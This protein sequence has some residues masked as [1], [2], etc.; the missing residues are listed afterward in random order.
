M[1][2]KQEAALR[3]A[4]EALK[5]SH[6]EAYRHTIT[7]IDEALADNALDKMADNARELGLDY[8]PAQQQEPVCDKC[9]GLGY[10]DEGHEC[11]DGSMAGGNYVEC[12]RCKSKQVRR[13]QELCW[14]DK[15]RAKELADG[16]SV[17]TTLTVHRP[18]AD[19]V[20]LYT[21][22]PAIKPWVGLSTEEMKEIAD[23]YHLKPPNVP[24]AF[25]AIEAKL[26]EKNNG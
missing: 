19:D 8:E 22:P 24:V 21:A 15:T 12:E 7:A 20:A 23:R 6:P 10:Y 9:H 3:L 18:F 4:R 5:E 17:T 1:T 14:I 11:D 25:R 2:P 13:A 16:N 26:R